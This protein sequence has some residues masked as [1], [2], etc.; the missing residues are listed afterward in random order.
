MENPFQYDLF[1]DLYI[2]NGQRFKSNPSL[3]GKDKSVDEKYDVLTGNY[4]PRGLP[5]FPPVEGRIKMSFF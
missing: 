4:L 3:P 5:Y 1:R 2:L